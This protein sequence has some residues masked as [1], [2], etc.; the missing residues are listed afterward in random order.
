MPKPNFCLFIQT[1]VLRSIITEQLKSWPDGTLREIKDWR[2]ITDNDRVILLDQAA[3]A[4][5]QDIEFSNC[6]PLLFGVGVTSG[7]DT[8]ALTESFSLPLRLGHMLARLQYHLTFADQHPCT[9]CVFGPF[10]LDTQQRVVRHQSGTPVIR[11]TEKESDLL[12]YLALQK[13]PV[14]REA[15]LT[16]VWGYDPAVETHTLETHVTQL[17]RKLDFDNSGQNWI[18][19]EQSTY[20]LRNEP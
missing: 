9:P 17:R 20:R 7:P 10:V 3:M 4:G 18:L 13:D 6:R 1:P 14:S 11:L 12:A 8:A 5:L 19:N 15:I 2:E 16:E